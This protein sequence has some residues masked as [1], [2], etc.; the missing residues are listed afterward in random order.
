M[1]LP[2]LRLSSCASS[3]MCCFTRPLYFCSVRPRFAADQVDQPL[4]SS[5]ALRAA[6]TALS[7]S[8]LPPSG[9]VA[10]TLPVAGLTTSNVWPS[11]ASTCSPPMTIFAR[12]ISS[13]AGSVPVGA[14]GRGVPGLWIPHRGHGRGPLL[15]I[16]ATNLHVPQLRV[17]HELAIDE[18]RRT[19]PR[20][21]GEDEDDT[22]L[23]SPGP[24]PHLR[25]ARGICVIEDHHRPL[26]NRSQRG[27]G[28]EVHPTGV[29]GRGG[30]RDTVNDDARDPD[31]H[32]R[33]RT[34]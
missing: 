5:S 34:G 10:M 7:T 14:G 9:A 31:T 6:A 32:R 2:T 11:E 15:G 1:G 13:A 25:H 19:H 23:P 12:R 24:E 29:D 16:P 8:G 28:I 22:E 18:K 20:P 30:L 4:G 17:R 26:K 33:I 21:Q 27:L 3:S